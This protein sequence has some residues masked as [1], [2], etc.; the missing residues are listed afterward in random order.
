MTDNL[1]LLEDK[2]LKLIAE[3]VK[4]KA[5]QLAPSFVA[6]YLTEVE[7]NV[8]K[9]GSYG[10]KLGV[11]LAKIPEGSPAKSARA[12]EYGSGVHNTRKGFKSKNQTT[13]NSTI[14][15]RPKNKK[16]L[17]FFWEVKEPPIKS[18][19]KV[20]GILDDGRVSMWHVDHPGV[21][22]V[23]NGQGYLRLAL[24]QSTN[25]I[26]ETVGEETAKNFKAQ[27]RVVFSR[28]GG[29]NK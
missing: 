23:N 2:D 1:N 8:R 26:K 21:Q 29:I 13:S 6:P 28:P 20:I 11:D 5:K 15:I 9:D 7:T 19:G 27:V 4:N 17:A 3:Y 22:A 14:T 18:G 25:Y 24:K 16:A 10:I 12:Y